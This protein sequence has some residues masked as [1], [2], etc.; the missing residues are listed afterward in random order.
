MLPLICSG[1]LTLL[2]AVLIL[3]RRRKAQNPALPANTPAILL[4]HVAFYRD[5]DAADKVLFEMRIKDFL[6]S[7]S[8]RGVDVAVED[9]DRILI[10]AGAIMLIFS[11]PDWQ[12]KNISEVILYKDTFNRDYDTDAS[13]RNVLGMVGDGALNG[14]MLLSRPSLRSSFSSAHDGHNTVLHEFAHLIDKA[15]GTIDGVPEY[16]LSR[17]QVLP[18]IKLVHECIKAMKAKGHSDINLYGASNDSEFFA[19]ISEYFFEHPDKLKD[20]HPE[21]YY[22]LDEMFHPQ[23]QTE[24]E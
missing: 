1:F 18:W 22:M 16:L 12:Y 19:V 7:T 15:D 13:G 14:T 8:I 6:S 5:L 17:P 23:T 20:H 24:G 11:F 4:E 3:R 9:L 21:L 10:A 2:F